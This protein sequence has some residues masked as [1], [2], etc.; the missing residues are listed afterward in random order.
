[1]SNKGL[2]IANE[3]QTA[4]SNK[5]DASNTVESSGITTI[6]GTLVKIN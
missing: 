2:S 5:G 4:I 3:A 6:K 1:M